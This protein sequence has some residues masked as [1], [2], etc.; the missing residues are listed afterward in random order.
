VT[1]G[2]V[3]SWTPLAWA[4][5]AGN[6]LLIISARLQ[7][8]EN[9]TNC[10]RGAPCAIS[11]QSKGFERFEEPPLR[12]AWGVCLPGATCQLLAHGASPKSRLGRG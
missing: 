6:G 5:V 7:R 4:W 8:T 9:S 3:F 12:N 11:S 10:L 2:G 1:K